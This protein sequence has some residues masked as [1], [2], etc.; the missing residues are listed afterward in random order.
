MFKKSQYNTKQKSLIFSEKP[1]DTN[2]YAQYNK[3]KIKQISLM[4]LND[5][6]NSTNCQDLA[7][8]QAST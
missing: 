5:R 4:K 7:R 6:P 2:K 1:L 8:K 3:L